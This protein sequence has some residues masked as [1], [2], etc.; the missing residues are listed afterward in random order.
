MDDLVLT[1]RV[2]TAG[3]VI[4]TEPTYELTEAGLAYIAEHSAS[5]DAP[6]PEA[7]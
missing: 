3:A 2:A 1:E 7:A 4:D 5:A 6:G